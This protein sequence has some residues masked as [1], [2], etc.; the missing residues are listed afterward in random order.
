M[1]LLYLV[2]IVLQVSKFSCL[3]QKKLSIPATVSHVLKYIPELQ[4][5]VKSLMKK[6]EEILA[7]I[8]KQEIETGFQQQQRTNDIGSSLS[9]VSASWLSDREVVIQLS[10]FKVQNSK[11]CEVLLNLEDDGFHLLNATSFESFGER[12]IYN[13]HLQVLYSFT[14]YN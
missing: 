3:L 6:K 2:I 1:E 12:V 4:A 5:Q 11:L 14:I 9:T 10:T 8:S 13:L 7:R